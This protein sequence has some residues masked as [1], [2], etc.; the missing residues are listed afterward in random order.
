M[1]VQE[2]EPAALERAGHSGLGW[3]CVIDLHGCATP[4][5]D[6]IAWV[7]RTMLEAARR[8]DATVV[9]EQFH[10]FEPHGISGVVVIGESHL[11]VHIWPERDFAAIDVFTCNSRLNM[12][13]A[14]EWLTDAF[15]ARDPRF[16]Y[17]IR[18]R[19]PVCTPRPEHPIQPRKGDLPPNLRADEP[20]D[21]IYID[22][23]DAIG[24]HWFVIN[25]TI[26]TRQ[27]AYQTAEILQ[28]AHFGRALVLDGKLQSAE[29]DEYIY[30]EALVQPAL[31]AHCQ[32]RRV[33]II[34]GGEGAT[35]REVLKH[36][37]I[38]EVVMVD[39]DN[40]MI[41]LAREHLQSWHRNA[42]DDPRLEVIICD[43]Y[44]FIRS[45]TERFNVIIVD[46]VDSFEDG[47]AEA[48][49][50]AEFYRT[51]KGRLAPGGIL[52]VQGMECDANT[53]EGH[54]HI[55][56]K[57]KELFGYVRSYLT[58]IPSYAA[59]WGFVMASDSIDPRAI[60]PAEI[61]H[62]ITGRGLARQLSFYD[63]NTHQGL[64]ALPKDLRAILGE[65]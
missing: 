7:R 19:D 48:L 47:P 39:I 24:G 63:G 62:T 52:V 60:S 16:I 2:I 13:S 15:G 34:G 12:R 53:W 50:T 58:F 10:R 4:F 23:D 44:E 49:Y 61:D 57:L 25:G 42:F 45:T 54:A 20:R 64:F 17:F 6:D 43:G 8:A 36:P 27:T 1:T 5:L 33:L 26:A 37:T 31:C 21:E 59:T 18:G 14:A 51:L 30:H 56:R 3:Q 28:F 29:R 22:H 9:N 46:I 40:Q 38:E 32:P 35:A 11:A 65:A 41:A 55:R